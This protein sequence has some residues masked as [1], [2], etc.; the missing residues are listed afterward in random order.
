VVTNEKDVKVKLLPR[1]QETNYAVLQFTRPEDKGQPIPASTSGP[2]VHEQS[3]ER[4]ILFRADEHGKLEFIPTPA[5]LLN[6]R[7]IFDDPV[8]ERAFGS[9]LISPQGAVGMVQEENSGMP[10][11]ANW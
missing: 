5:H 1:D 9:L 2:A 4:L 8:D 11:R 7:I 6:G 3:W 10:L